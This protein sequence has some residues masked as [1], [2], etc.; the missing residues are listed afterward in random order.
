MRVIK[1]RFVDTSRVFGQ[2]RKLTVAILQPWDYAWLAQT[3]VLLHTMLSVSVYI[4]QAPPS[5]TLEQ[6]PGA[7]TRNLLLHGGG[8]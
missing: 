4:S 7:V 3:L 1:N 8:S 2:L 5:P 6:T